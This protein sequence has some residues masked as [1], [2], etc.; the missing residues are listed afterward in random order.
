MGVLW[1]TEDFFLN[2]DLG[3][4]SPDMHIYKN[5]YRLAN[6]SFGELISLTIGK[7]Q[8]SN[9]DYNISYYLKL[10]SSGEFGIDGMQDLMHRILTLQPVN[11]VNDL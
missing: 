8:I 6:R 11:Y 5:E 4:V 9:S 10:V 2:L 7:N 1:E 3:I